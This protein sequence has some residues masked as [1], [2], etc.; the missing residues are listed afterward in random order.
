MRAYYSFVEAKNIL[1]S[2]IYISPR[3]SR[4]LHAEIDHVLGLHAEFAMLPKP[5]TVKLANITRTSMR[6]SPI[7]YTSSAH[8]T[9]LRSEYPSKGKQLLKPSK[10]MIF[11]I[12]AKNK[13]KEHRMI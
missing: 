5:E 6:E 11:K 4:L 10:R 2:T 13:T 3:Q 7:V 9:L 12:S 8:P 1:R